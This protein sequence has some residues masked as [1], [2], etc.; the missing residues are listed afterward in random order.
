MTAFDIRPYDGAGPLVFGMSPAEVH[1]SLGEQPRNTAW[2]KEGE[3]DED[4]PA[5]SACYTKGTDALVEFALTSTLD[6]RFQGVS[7]FT[8]PNAVEILAAADGA[9]LEGLGSIVFLALGIAVI[10]FDSDQESDRVVQVFQRGRWDAIK[11]LKPYTPM[12]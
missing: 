12:M 11:H 4:Y 3:R 8:A 7:L 2:T 9:P 5:L 10:D 1:A 6:V